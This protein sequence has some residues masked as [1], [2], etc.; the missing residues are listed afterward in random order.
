M[1]VQQLTALG[2]TAEVWQGQVAQYQL[3]ELQKEG[4]GVGG[5]EVEPRKQEGDNEREKGMLITRFTVEFVYTV[6]IRRSGWKGG[7]GRREQVI[8]GSVARC[9]NGE[10]GELPAPS[11]VSAG[12]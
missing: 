4:G 9:V 2:Q 7:V 11:R 12:R 10:S 1:L 3:D 6:L 8:A 5:E